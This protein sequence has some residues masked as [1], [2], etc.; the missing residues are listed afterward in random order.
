MLLF[1]LL[2]QALAY[3]PHRNN[4]G[5]GSNYQNCD[6]NQQYVSEMHTHW[7]GFDNKVVAQGNDAETMLY[8]AKHNAN[9]NTDQGSKSGNQPTFQHKDSFDEAIACP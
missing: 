5:E 7:I 2:H 3:I 6:E 9:H 4:D 1:I 8:Q